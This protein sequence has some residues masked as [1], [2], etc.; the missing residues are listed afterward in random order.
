MKAR[1]QYI[2]FAK[3]CR[4]FGITRQAYY[5][6]FNQAVNTALQQEL[7]IKEVLKIRQYHPRIGTRKL[8]IML[9]AFMLSHQIK[10][11]RDALFNLLSQYNLLIRKRRSNIKTTQSHHWLK[12]YPNLIKDLTPT[13]PNQL[14]VSD[15]TYWKINIGYVYISLITDAYSHKIVGY[16]LSETLDADSSLKAL[17]MA[18]LPLDT[19]LNSSLIHHSDRG[20][21]YCSHKYVNLLQQN[22]IDVSMTEN[23]DPLENAIAERVNGILKEEYLDH[24]DLRNIT[25]AKILLDQVIKLYNEDRPHMSIGNLVPSLVHQNQTIKIEKKWKNYYQRKQTVNLF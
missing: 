13:K 15:I 12:K 19:K 10:M 14:Y 20:V 22:S 6:H 24:Y 23:G 4:L 2:G 7:I 5:Q 18:L 25:E 11:G 9:E 16:H 3:L 1:H 17:K 21:Q 8:Y